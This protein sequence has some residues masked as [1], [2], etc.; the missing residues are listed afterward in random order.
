[1]NEQYEKISAE[2]I[3]DIIEKADNPKFVAEIMSNHFHDLDRP[4]TVSIGVESF[5]DVNSGDV[6]LKSAEELLDSDILKTVNLLRANGIDAVPYNSEDA[7][8]IGKFVVDRSGISTPML[9]PEDAVQVTADIA[10]ILKNNGDDIKGFAFPQT[11][12]SLTHYTNE[13]KQGVNVVEN[14]YGT[15]LEQ[16]IQN[17]YGQSV[18]EFL[19]QQT[20]RLQTLP[21]VR[22]ED[23]ANDYTTGYRGGSFGSQPYAVLSARRSKDLAYFSPDANVAKIYSAGAGYS[24]EIGIVAAVNL[25]E[26][27]K[28]YKDWGLESRGAEQQRGRRAYE[29]IGLSH[30]NPVKALYMIKNNKMYQIADENGYINREMELFAKLH[31][32]KSLAKTEVMCER[33]NLLKDTVEADISQAVRPYNKEKMLAPY[34]A[35]R[36][37]AAQ[38]FIKQNFL[39]SEVSLT[40]GGKYKLDKVVAFGSQPG[41][42]Q[43]KIEDIV[44]ICVQDIEFKKV[45]ISNCM[46][47]DNPLLKDIQN[48]TL[49]ACAVENGKDI[50]DGTVFKNCQFKEGVDLSHLK[51][52][53]FIDCAFPDNV[54]LPQSVEFE[55]CKLS[56]HMDLS[57]RAVTISSSKDALIDDVLKTN[58]DKAKELKFS[59]IFQAEDASLSNKLKSC[60]ISE[61]KAIRVKD[62]ASFDIMD[63]SLPCIAIDGETAHLRNVKTTRLDEAGVDLRSQKNVKFYGDCHLSGYDADFFISPRNNIKADFSQCTSLDVGSAHSP[64]AIAQLKELPLSPETKIKCSDMVQISGVEDLKI[65]GRSDMSNLKMMIIPEDTASF[66][67]DVNDAG[68]KLPENVG[69][70][71][72]DSNR[73]VPVIIASAAN[74]KYFEKNN[75]VGDDNKGFREYLTPEEFTKKTGAEF[76]KLEVK[77]EP[78]V[79]EK[80]KTS[81]NKENNAT[82][83]GIKE[84]IQS[85]NVFAKN[86]KTADVPLE[87]G[88]YSSQQDDNRYAQFAE[89]DAGEKLRK[90]CEEMQKYNPELHK[91]IIADW[92]EQ[93]S[94]KPITTMEQYND[95]ARNVMMQYKS[96]LQ[97]HVETMMQQSE[98][99]SSLE[100]V[101]AG[102]NLVKLCTEVS[103]TDSGLGNKIMADWNTA[104]AAQSPTKMEQYDSIARDIMNQHKFDLMPHAENVVKSNLYDNL[105]E[106]E[107]DSKLRKLCEDVKQ[108]DP[109]LYQNITTSW[110]LQYTA[111]GVK[112]MDQANSVA[113]DMMQRYKKELIPYAETCFKAEMTPQTP[114][115]MPA[116]QKMQTNKDMTNSAIAAA[117]K[118][119]LK[120]MSSAEQ[121][122]HLTDMRNG[123]NSLSNIGYPASIANK[124]PNNSKIKENQGAGLSAINLVAMQQVKGNGL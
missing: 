32:V 34:E 43:Q 122:K 47:D 88:E 9:K 35:K 66:I 21:E 56:Q 3:D 108:K 20:E 63:N 84:K 30:K 94:A 42:E 23:L 71:Y 72:F 31:D 50:P 81:N 113:K 41:D 57:G 114:I 79:T 83:G 12:E 2:K 91:K 120:S 53:K 109:A 19:Q 22:V 6:G 92:N 25:S 119:E 100:S 60:D 111:V 97:P 85:D 89:K 116:E 99:L 27:Q 51:N 110:N 75:Q 69:L 13:F 62:K 106:K 90:L 1:M 102:Q 7:K 33:G 40:E 124:T 105:I 104:H 44:P 78:K 73:G 68:L 59:G 8:D 55:D 112:T 76:G 117:E 101:N 24:T 67:K 29:T 10:D 39:E 80:Q 64:F 28:F 107:P 15:A 49:T 82:G 65:V 86:E 45:V 74:R 87:P 4:C 26:D 16:Q 5:Y 61:L 37:M 52:A 118:R 11:A 36:D 48:L 18:D 96:A 95:V 17:E 58:I 121:G 98:M 54:K 46:V 77:E 38:E 14:N 93:H 123:Y 103:K 115:Q 70:M